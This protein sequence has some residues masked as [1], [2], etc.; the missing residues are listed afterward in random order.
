M[1]GLSFKMGKGRTKRRRKQKGEFPY[2]F[3][4]K[5]KPE[6][7][8]GQACRIKSGRKSEVCVVEFTDGAA[9]HVARKQVVKANA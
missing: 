3:K 8:E 1:R 5:V 7:R 6:G 4:G 2:V 9:F